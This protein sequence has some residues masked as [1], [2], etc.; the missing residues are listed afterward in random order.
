MPLRKLSDYVTCVSFDCSL[1]ERQHPFCRNFCSKGVYKA[2]N[3][4]IFI[5]WNCW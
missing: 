3:L 4:G 1:T 2:T 5:L